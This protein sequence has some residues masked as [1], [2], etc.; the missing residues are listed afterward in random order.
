VRLE[1]YERQ[2]APLLDYYQRTGRL[3][4][5]DGTRSPEDIYDEIEQILNKEVVRTIPAD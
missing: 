5:V 4:R 1:T 3:H 2:T